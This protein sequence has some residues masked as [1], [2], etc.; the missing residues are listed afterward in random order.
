MSKR[1]LVRGAPDFDATSL[2]GKDPKNLVPDSPPFGKI[3]GVFAAIVG[4]VLV[5]KGLR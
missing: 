2:R 4:F 1:G 5:W 3:F